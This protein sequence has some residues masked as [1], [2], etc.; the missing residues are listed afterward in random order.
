MGYKFA[1]NMLGV[2]ALSV[3]AMC[4]EP[5]AAAEEFLGLD[6]GGSLGKDRFERYVPSVTNPLFNE[7]P[8]I[9]TEA[10]PVYIF[11]QVPDEFISGGGDI[12]VAALQVRLAITERFGFIATADGYTNLDFNETLDDDDGPN[13]VAFGF[14]YAFWNDPE[15]G[16]IGTFGLRYTAPAG[17]LDTAGLEIN[18]DGSGFLNPFFTG[19]LI[20]D[21]FQVQGS[22]GANIA[23]NG[24]NSTFIHG[25][26]HVDY[27]VFDG[28]Y[29]FAEAN[30]FAFTDGGDQ[31]VGGP[32]ATLTGVDIVDLGTS[33]PQNF[34]TV[35]GG[36]RYRLGDNVLFGTGVEGNVLNREDTLFGIRLTTDFTI[37]F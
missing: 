23:L 26:I 18:G 17:N 14:K 20:H 7:T 29:P 33:D 35:G 31:I 36:F 4:A 6:I 32:L 9:T 1:A 19:A 28:F 34:V 2:A 5:A 10:K 16:Q 3:A 27:E 22:L 13:D 12:N 25:S 37:H 24:I 21:K 8:F 11:H 30:F 15:A